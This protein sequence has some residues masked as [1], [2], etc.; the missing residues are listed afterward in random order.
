MNPPIE[1]LTAILQSAAQEEL[2]PRFARV[3]REFKGDGS[4]VTEAD[5][6]MQR[7]LS[8]ALAKNWPQIP[9]LGEEMSS[10]EQQALLNTCEQGLWL[11]D[12]LDG[13][14][15]FAAGIPYFCISLALI[16]GG[17]VVLGIVYDPL[18][19]ECFAAEKGRG[20]TLNGQVLQVSEH[21]PPISRSMG[22]IDFKRLDGE[23]AIRLATQPPYSSQRSFGSG[24]LDWCMIATGRCHLY[25]HGGQK[26]WDYAAGQLILTESGG[27]SSTLQKEPVLS[28]HLR[29]R[30]VVAATNHDLFHTWREWL[31]A[32]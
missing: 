6:A 10:E 23:L 14:S 1:K 18:R 25:L 11:L 7:R 29:P 13:T 30:S 31:L 5:T 3:E 15:N 8:E 17:E 28:L 4:I 22:L 24:A 21:C 16:R 26:L 20:A 2:L 27:Q 32:A 19:E 9:L 12:P